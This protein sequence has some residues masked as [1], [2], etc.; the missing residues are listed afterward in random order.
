MESNNSPE[1]WIEIHDVSPGWAYW[2][3]E[4]ITN[5]TD[6]HPTRIAKKVLFIIPNHANNTPLSKYPEYSRRLVLLEKR[7]YILGLHGYTHFYEEMNTTLDNTKTLIDMGRREFE[8]EGFN[9]PTY[10]V[11]PGWVSS[12]EVSEYLESTFEYVYYAGTMKT[13]EGIKRYPTHEYTWYATDADAA[14]ADAKEDYENST[15]VFRLT[16]HVGAANT[17]GGL[18]FL[19]EFL[20]WLD[21]Q[22]E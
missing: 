19:E 17:P 20:S 7:G 5:I 21:M 9:D 12:E 6:R 10:F 4:E 18:A 13:P 2:R 1:V 8:E 11:P 14:L 22:N 15:K 3:L 16:I